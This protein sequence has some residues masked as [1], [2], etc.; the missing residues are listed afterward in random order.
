MAK[1]EGAIPD[2]SLYFVGEGQQS[3]G[4]RDRRSVLADSLGDLLMGKSEV[5]DE[6]P[7]A[8]RLFDGI[9]I[10]ALKVFDEGERKQ[11]LIGNVSNDGWDRTPTE[12]VGGAEPP[13][14]CDEFVFP[15]L[16]RSHS[17]RL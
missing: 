3:Q 16:P 12:S 4:I 10:F 17:D 15:V 14:T 7:V 8:F 5:I 1:G 11:L 2:E 9:E 13:L 6:L